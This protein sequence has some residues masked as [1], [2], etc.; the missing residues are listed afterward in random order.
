MTAHQTSAFFDAS[1]E[2]SAR[3]VARQAEVLEKGVYRGP[4]YY[5]LTPMIRIMLDLGRLEE[6]PSNRIPDFVDRLITLLPRLERHGCS[7]KRRGGFLERLRAG[8]W[9]GHVAEH[10]A[11][12]LQSMAG[13]RVTR[14]KTPSLKG[15]PGVYNLMFAYAYEEAGLLAGRTAL[16]LVNSLLPPELAGI[17]RLDRIA[18]ADSEFDLARRLEDLRRAAARCAF[19]P[20]T[21]SLVDEARRRGIPV[22]RLDEASLVQ[23]GHGRHQKRLRASVTGQTSLIGA[24]IAS[25]KHLTKRLLD[26][27]GVPVPRGVLVSD[28]EDALREARRLGFPLVTKPLDGNHGRGIR[29]GI[30][31]EDQLRFGFDLAREH[32]RRIVLEQFFPAATTASWWWT[33][34]S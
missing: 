23:L 8:T 10:V 34:S 4:H 7:L 20:T 21:Q 31:D 32:G 12:E 6:W 17:G 1:D 28:V 3:L 18:P 16:E 13:P 24:D 29:T 2:G 25:H 27:T 22:M 14:G 30:M 19:G 33:A 5:S 15:K 26:E 9:L 11:L